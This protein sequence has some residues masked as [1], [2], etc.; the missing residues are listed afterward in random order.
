ML[1]Q[2]RT[3][4][5]SH[6]VTRC[7]RSLIVMWLVG[8]CCLVQAKQL[9]VVANV[10]N[11]ATDLTTAELVK[12]F[13]VRT[14]SW[15]DGKPIKLVLRDP[16][17]TDM[18]LVLRKLLARTPEQAQTFVQ[19]HRPSIVIVDSDD[20]VIKFVATNRGSVGVVDLFSLTKDVKV[21]KIDGKLPVEQGYVLRGNT[22]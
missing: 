13:N 14:Q 18:H 15:P 5:K 6:I 9:A 19:A 20:A 16:S 8:A 22:Q 7:R 2:N 10:A 11:A 3:R 4:L 12:I 21:L 1:R 17:C